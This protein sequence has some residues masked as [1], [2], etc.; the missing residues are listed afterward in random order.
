MQRN[1][2]PRAECVWP[3]P[4]QLLNARCDLESGHAGEKQRERGQNHLHHRRDRS[5][6][7]GQVGRRRDVG[8]RLKAIQREQQ[9]HEAHERSCQRAD[10]T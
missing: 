8:P 6:D 4:S 5:H 3:I 2:P 10:E 9:D 7:K 1:D